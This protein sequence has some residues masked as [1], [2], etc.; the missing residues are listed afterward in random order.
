[1]E[2]KI[3]KQKFNEKQ[4]IYSRRVPFHLILINYRGNNNNPMVE[5]PVA[6]PCNQQFTSNGTNTSLQVC[7]PEEHARRLWAIPAKTHHLS[8]EETDKSQSRNVL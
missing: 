6:Q 8:H 5:K 7:C 3:R 2:A 1:M 4:D